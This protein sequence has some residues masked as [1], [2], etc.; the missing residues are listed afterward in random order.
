MMVTPG[1][2]SWT[3]FPYDIIVP[4]RDPSFAKLFERLDFPYDIVRLQEPFFSKL[5]S[6]SLSGPFPSH[7]IKPRENPIE[8]TYSLPFHES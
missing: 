6:E 7:S 8:T 5:I 4:G 3:D 1:D 2:H